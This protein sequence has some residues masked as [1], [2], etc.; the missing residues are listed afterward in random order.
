MPGRK[1]RPGK[2]ACGDDDV[3]GRVEHDERRLALPVGL[4][5]NEDRVAVAVDLKVLGAKILDRLKVEQ[6]I[7]S[8][9]LYTK[10]ILIKQRYCTFLTGIVVAVD[11]FPT[12][13][14]APL[15]DPHG[16]DHVAHHGNKHDDAKINVKCHLH[17]QI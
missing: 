14:G 12:E 5:V 7:D 11:H 3:L 8:Y 15:G 4:V 1:H 2:E 10:I 17:A 16:H 13:L 9:I 6:G